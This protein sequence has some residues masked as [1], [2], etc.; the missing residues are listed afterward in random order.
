MYTKQADRVKFAI[1]LA[2]SGKQVAACCST[3]ETLPIPTVFFG[4]EEREKT[5]EKSFGLLFGIQ[6]ILNP[7]PPQ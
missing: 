1:Y 7:R 2:T 4:R 6:Y 5:G 3:K